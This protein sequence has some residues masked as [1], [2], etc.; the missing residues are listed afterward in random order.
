MAGACPDI[1]DFLTNAP[2]FVEDEAEGESQLR[3]GPKTFDDA[4]EYS[5][6]IHRA[7]SPV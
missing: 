6:T 2:K 7:L 1:Q 5:S 3:K 4:I